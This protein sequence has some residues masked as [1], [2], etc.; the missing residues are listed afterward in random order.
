MIRIVE[1]VANGFHVL[2][3]RVS[4][5]RACR[6][7]RVLSSFPLLSH[8]VGLSDLTIDHSDILDSLVGSELLLE[9]SSEDSKGH[10]VEAIVPPELGSQT[11]PA[12][13]NHLK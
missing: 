6:I 11:L 5:E 1:G 12:K 13:R 2:R 3:E 9:N 4:D 10:I 8:L 7:E